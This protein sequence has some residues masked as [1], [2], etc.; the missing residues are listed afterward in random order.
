MAGISWLLA[1]ASKCPAVEY[2][3]EVDKAEEVNNTLEEVE[4]EYSYGVESPR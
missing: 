2:V 4:Y 3:Y 1:E